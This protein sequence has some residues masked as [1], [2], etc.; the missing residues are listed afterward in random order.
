MFIAKHYKKKRLYTATLHN[1]LILLHTETNI[2]FTFDLQ[3]QYTNYAALQTRSFA[4][5]SNLESISLPLLSTRI[6]Q[7]KLYPPASRI[8]SPYL[9]QQSV[10]RAFVDRNEP[11]RVAAK[12]V[13]I[14]R[15]DIEPER[16]DVQIVRFEPA[17][18]KP[19]RRHVLDLLQ[20]VHLGQLVLDRKVVLRIDVRDELAERRFGRE[21]ER[22]IEPDFFEV[23]K[24]GQA[25]VGVLAQPRPQRR[26]APVVLRSEEL[27]R[28]SDA[29]HFGSILILP[30]RQT[31]DLSA[32]T[33]SSSLYNRCAR[34][35]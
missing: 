29:T 24:L 26:Y 25:R 17:L 19:V 1:H 9:V 30:T 14:A 15:V 2:T 23:L 16:V 21:D 28:I 6:A 18:E 12:E 7:L 11:F 32:C 33:A 4:P 31:R 13:D 22:L 5:D 10:D 8:I 27:V 35:R 20:R 34:R 3:S